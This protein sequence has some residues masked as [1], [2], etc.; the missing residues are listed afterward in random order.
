MKCKHR[1]FCLYEDIESKFELLKDLI[2]ETSKIIIEEKDDLLNIQIPLPLINLP[3][4]IFEIEEKKEL[5]KEKKYIS[6]N[7]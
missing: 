1:S 6:N 2:K 3:P 4:M 5:K 7:K